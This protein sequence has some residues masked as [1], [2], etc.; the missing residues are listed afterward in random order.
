MMLPSQP[1]NVSLTPR[2]QMPGHCKPRS[3]S[4]NA[5]TPAID[6]LKMNSCF[7]NLPGP[8]NINRMK[9]QNSFCS[10]HKNEI[11]KIIVNTVINW[12]HEVQGGCLAK[13][14]NFLS[15]FSFSE[16][17]LRLVCLTERNSFAYSK[18]GLDLLFLYSATFVTRIVLLPNIFPMKI[19]SVC[20]R[21]A[22]MK[23]M[24][25]KWKHNT[26]WLSTKLHS[27]ELVLI[28]LKDITF[29]LPNGEK[30]LGIQ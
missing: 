17:I 23:T 3:E 6:L 10:S 27:L 20:H 12:K 30:Q 5:F 29:S 26:V 11:M 4:V 7:A 2:K 25:W 1:L 15:A 22:M 18:I 9:T 21:N 8:P 24:H 19:V 16:I 13:V 14:W 28:Q